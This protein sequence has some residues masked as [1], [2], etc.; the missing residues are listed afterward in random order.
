[1]LE[2]QDLQVHGRTELVRVRHSLVNVEIF[3]KHLLVDCF[4]PIQGERQ[5]GGSLFE[6][7]L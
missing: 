4:L 6:P 5:Q 1:M 7:L 2:A 3:E